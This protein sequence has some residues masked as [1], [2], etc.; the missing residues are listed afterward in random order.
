M[1]EMPKSITPLENVATRMYLA[2]ASA[3]FFFNLSKATIHARGTEAISR[4][5]KNI[6]NEPEDII[7]YIPR[8]VLNINIKN[9]PQYLLFDDLQFTICLP[10][11]N[12]VR[13]M[14]TTMSV[15][16]VR[17]IFITLTIGV[18]T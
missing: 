18:V 7:M 1:N 13:D 16:A 10:P 17:M 15:P 14:M 2:A 9:S 5:R 11:S 3:L 4:P 8:S 12:H 6:R